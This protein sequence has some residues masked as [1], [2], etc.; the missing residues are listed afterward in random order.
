M[1]GNAPMT[2]TALAEPASGI[3]QSQA[4]KVAIVDDSAVVRGL[5]ARW[6]D[7]DPEL[8]VCGRFANGKLAVEGVARV[9]PD[10]IIL[11][12][13]M[14]VMDGL[15]AL[16]GLLQ[17]APDS[18]VIMASTLTRKNAEVSLKALSLGATDYIPKP[19]SNRGITTSTQFRSE[20]I[21]KIKALGQPEKGSA[22]ARKPALADAPATVAPVAEAATAEKP[23]FTL[24]AFSNV[25]PRILAIGSSTG[26]PQA[27]ASL[28]GAIAPSI[29]NMPVVITQHMPA[30]FTAILAERLGRLTGLPAK[31][32]E[33]GELLL[34]GHIYVARGG[35]H[36]AL[37][38]REG[39]AAIRVYDGDLVNFCKPAVDPLF[40]S[41]AA[42]FG[43]ATLALILTGMGH[44]GAAGGKVIA[45]AGGSIIAQDQATSVVWGM[46]GA[47]AAAGACAAVLPLDRIG[48]K[49]NAL[50]AGGTA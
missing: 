25:R 8:E 7:E 20:L 33:D 35:M 39:N 10:I 45:D 38:N 23:S 4:I 26:G 47:A 3:S 2:S 19:E 37:A 27:L 21:G 28:M 16:P 30:T 17:N 48:A 11:D 31:E 12:I 43:S 29:R 14:P 1:Q 42:I 34:P 36:M 5:V 41:V 44:D 50:I 22:I 46:P 13:E 18:K 32:G 9:S 15:T 6:I 40:E 49:V 24:R